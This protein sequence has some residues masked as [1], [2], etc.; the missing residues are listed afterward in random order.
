MENG[1]LIF[2]LTA[3]PFAGVISMKKPTMKLYKYRNGGWRSSKCQAACSAM[4]SHKSNKKYSNKMYGQM[5]RWM[6]IEGPPC[7]ARTFARAEH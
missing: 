2:L 3:V 5:L 1:L 7:V 6:F 4:L